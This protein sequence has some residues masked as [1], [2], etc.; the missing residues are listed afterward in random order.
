MKR[1]VTT[2]VVVLA[3]VAA[4]A[5]LQ[6]AY[7]TR[8]AP[9]RRAPTPA[10]A[11]PGDER[12]AGQDGAAAAAAIGFDR[13]PLWAYGFDTPA[14]AGDTARPQAPPSRNLRPGEDPD[15]QRRPRHVDGSS[16][17]YSLIDIRDLH[18]VIDWFP[19]DH[20]PM[21][22]V[23]AHGPSRLGD[24]ARGC[25]SCHLPNGKGRPENAPVAGLPTAYFVRQ[26]GDYRSGRRRSAD[27][28]KPNTNTMIDLARAMTDDEVLAA[29]TYFGSIKWTP[30]IRVVEADRVPHMRLENNLF[31]PSGQPG[32]E[33]I[34][35]RIIETPESEEQAEFRRNPRS[36][37]V[38]Y[39]PRGSIGQGRE[40]VTTGVRKVS[41]GKTVP[42]TTTACRACHGVDLAGV[43][44][45]PPIVGRSPSYIVRQ[46]W[47]IQQ[48]M[49]NG[50][51]SQSMKIVVANLTADDMRAI[52]AYLASRRP[53]AR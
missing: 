41:D 6:R 33:A 5:I 27:P 39:V 12:R 40:L 23:V 22:D 8:R 18:N 37:F 29:A 51:S 45:V 48:G 2:L 50:A 34:G 46:M 19:A 49:R 32:T 16:A 20:P 3:C 25:G 44:D 15:E 14:R 9:T 21:P 36:G 11:A 17:A 42:G 28:R 4:A 38:A 35:G 26:I 10:A 43:A 31:L 7:D 30:W 13:E 24:I 53:G 47:D 1:P 52:A